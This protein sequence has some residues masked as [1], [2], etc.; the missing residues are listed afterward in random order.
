MQIQKIENDQQD[1]IVGTESCGRDRECAKSD[2]FLLFLA[3]R[4]SGQN[5]EPRLVSQVVQTWRKS[6]LVLGGHSKII[7]L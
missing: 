1:R 5:G 4:G 3:V 2:K 6:G 7:I